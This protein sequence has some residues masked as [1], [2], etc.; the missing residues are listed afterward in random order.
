MTP[1]VVSRGSKPARASEDFPE[2]LAPTTNRYGEPRLPASR[3]RSTARAVS[4]LRPKNTGACLAPNAVEAAEWRTLH[5]DRPAHH[6]A[7]RDLVGDPLAQQIFQLR[8]EVVFRAVLIEGRLEV[9][10]LGKEP[11]LEEAFERLPVL[12]DLFRFGS[13]IGTEGDEPAKRNT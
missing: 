6:A 9:A 12:L 11:F 3:H 10:A 1:G 8:L 4:W 13:S 5:L 7:A 2:P